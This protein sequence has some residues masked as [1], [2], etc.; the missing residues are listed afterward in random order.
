MSGLHV[1]TELLARTGAVL[2]AIGDEL[3]AWLREAFA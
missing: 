3:A 1:D 2:R